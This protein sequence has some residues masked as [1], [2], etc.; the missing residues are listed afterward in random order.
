MFQKIHY[1]IHCSSCSVAFTLTVAAVLGLCHPQPGLTLRLNGALAADKP[2]CYC[3][4]RGTRHRIWIR[5]T[6]RTC[7]VCP[8]DV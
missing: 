8:A 6:G 1:G 5:R 3:R 2:G 7:D 4:E